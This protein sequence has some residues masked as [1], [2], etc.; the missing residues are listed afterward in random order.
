MV[1]GGSPA[2]A[3]K[4]GL[5]QILEDSLEQIPHFRLKEGKCLILQMLSKKPFSPLCVLPLQKQNAM[6][7]SMDAL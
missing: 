7:R 5:W 1:T 6:F 2:T 4:A 3:S